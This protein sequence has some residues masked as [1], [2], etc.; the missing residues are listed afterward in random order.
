MKT[1]CNNIENKYLPAAIAVLFAVMMLLAVSPAF[2]QS[3]VTFG[4]KVG[5]SQS[6]L[7]GTD[8]EDIKYRNS[9]AAGAF[10]KLAPVPF[11]V[12]QPEFLFRKKGAVNERSAVGLREEYQINYFEVPVLAKLRL[13]IA[14][15]V[16]PNIFAGPYYAYNTQASYTIVQTDTDIGVQRDVDVKRSDYGGIV[17][18]GV[19]FEFSVLFLSLDARY[20]FGAT[21]IEDANDALDLK[22]RD[23]NVMGGVGINF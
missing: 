5:Y 15:I 2:S 9:I 18:A 8:V 23:W 10:L 22:N 3:K 21:E 12:I 11:F 6:Y 20:G 1:S 13:P 16:Y 17:G 19:D 14:G 7:D 4:G